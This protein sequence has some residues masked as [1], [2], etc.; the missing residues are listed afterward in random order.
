MVE[1]S[2]HPTLYSIRTREARG[3]GILT[4]ETADWNL[5]KSTQIKRLA[6]WLSRDRLPAYAAS[7]HKAPVW[8]REPEPGQ[9]ALALLNASLDPADGL[10]L[11]LRTEQERI[12]V[13]DMACG[14]KIVCAATQEGP[15]RTFRL[16]HVGAWEVRLV[17]TRI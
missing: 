9:L 14:R 11:A 15:Y 10:V 13:I 17:V 1:A 12:Q 6:R 16:P 4:A 2:S 7:F 5:A 8:A 3:R